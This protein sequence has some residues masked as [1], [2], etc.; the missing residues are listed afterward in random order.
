MMSILILKMINEN[1]IFLAIQ[2]GNHFENNFNKTSI[3]V[4]LWTDE[5]LGI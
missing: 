3:N 2:I 5:V 1:R 4:W